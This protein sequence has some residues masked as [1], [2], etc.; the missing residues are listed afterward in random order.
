MFILDAD[1]YESIDWLPLPAPLPSPLSFHSLSHPL[2][3]LKQY[4]AIFHF[5]LKLELT[6]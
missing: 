3:K 5:F 1:S 6:T 4:I 2:L